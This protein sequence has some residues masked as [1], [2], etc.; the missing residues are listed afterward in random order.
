[1]LAVHGTYGTAEKYTH[2]LVGKPEGINNMD[3]RI[4]LK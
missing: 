4:I 3:R 2:G 1:M